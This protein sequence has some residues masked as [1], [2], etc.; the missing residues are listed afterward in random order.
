MVG[1]SVTVP[2]PPQRIVSLVPSLTELL[3][4]LG[5]GD[6]IVGRTDYCTRPRDTVASVPTVG[7]PIDFSTDA[8]LGLK[9]DLVLANDHENRRDPV[10]NLAS[11]VPVFVTSVRDTV[12]KVTDTATDATT[13]ADRSAGVSYRFTEAV[14][15]LIGRYIDAF[16][17]P[18]K[19]STFS[20]FAVYPIRPTRHI[21]P[22]RAPSPAPISI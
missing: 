16:N 1:R 14:D 10:L 4:D 21:L 3:F 17:A 7:G 18:I 19:R 6:R 13:L 15:K 5:L 22:A 8:V 9:P 20:R 2:V 11:K 12:G